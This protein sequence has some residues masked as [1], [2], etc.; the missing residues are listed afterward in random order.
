MLQYPSEEL[1]NA[2]LVPVEPRLEAEDTIDLTLPDD[3]DENGIPPQQTPSRGRGQ[4][5]V[6]AMSPRASAE[7]EALSFPI[8]FLLLRRHTANVP[9]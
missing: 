7:A 9:G 3:D 4:Q 6:T 2:G 5:P 1:N 8:L